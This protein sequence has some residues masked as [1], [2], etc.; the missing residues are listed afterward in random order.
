MSL[1]MNS[2]QK[3]RESCTL[4]VGILYWFLI[5][6]MLIGGKAETSQRGVKGCSQLLMCKRSLKIQFSL[7]RSMPF[8]MTV[9]TLIWVVSFDILEWKFLKRSTEI[10]ELPTQKKSNTGNLY[11]ISLFVQFFSFLLIQ[12]NSQRVYFKQIGEILNVL[13]SFVISI[14][15]E[16]ADS[17]VHF[18][19]LIK[20]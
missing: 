4:N 7:W 1:L 19:H 17:C 15:S 2:D 5:K 8:H 13:F 3:K 10:A 16:D 9:N 14:D 11:W 6:K 20:Q 12:N 18:C